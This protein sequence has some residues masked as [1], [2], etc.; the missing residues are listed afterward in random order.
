MSDEI[1]HHACVARNPV[2]I[3][4]S[5]INVDELIHFDVLANMTSSNMI[6]PKFELH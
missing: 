3:F 5:N 2:I 6:L 1:L 4:I